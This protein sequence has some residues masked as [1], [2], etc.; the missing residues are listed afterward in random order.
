MKR[1]ND[2]RKQGNPLL[3]IPQL[4]FHLLEIDRLSVLPCSEDLHVSPRLC[5]QVAQG[6]ELECRLWLLGLLPPLGWGARFPGGWR[7]QDACIPAG[8]I[9]QATDASEVWRRAGRPGADVDGVW[10]GDGKVPLCD[11][12]A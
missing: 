4:L 12:C 9:E 6:R 1:M 2:Q 10:S 11:E 8:S 3:K 7:G 5:D